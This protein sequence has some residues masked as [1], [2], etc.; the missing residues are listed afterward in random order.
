MSVGQNAFRT[1]AVSKVT[2]AALYPGDLT[3]PGMA[4]MKILF[5]RRPH[6]IVKAIDTSAAE[7]APGVIAVFTAKDVPN[8]EYGLIMPDQPVL[9]GPG[10]N[11]TWGD[12]VRFIGDQIALVVAETEKQAEHAR[13]LIEVAYEDLPV[14]TDPREAMKSRRGSRK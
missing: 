9:V 7:Q 2:G 14:L 13:D 4:H 6:A 8:N 10:S 5:A 1:D 11:K 3:L 12:H